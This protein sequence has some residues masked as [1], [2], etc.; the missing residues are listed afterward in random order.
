MKDTVKILARAFADVARTTAEDQWPALCDATIA[1][2]DKYQSPKSAL[3]RFRKLAERS[4]Y[5]QTNTMLLTI[6]S[7]SGTLGEKTN[8][9]VAIF[10][11]LSG[12][13]I[14]LIQKKDASLIG[15]MRIA[16][17]DERID[18]TLHG[19]LARIS[20]VMGNPL[21]FSH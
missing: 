18:A 6:V 16:F 20:T 4:V 1:L 13:H 12:R 21:S 19:Q 5:R 3:R 7:P 8:D 11:K 17:D 9:F 10:E 15:G 14:E 2:L